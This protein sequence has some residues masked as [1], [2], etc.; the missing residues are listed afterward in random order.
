V[1]RHKAANPVAESNELMRDS[2]LILDE[3]MRFLDCSKGSKEPSKSL[4]DV[5]VQDALN[6]AGFD[7]QAFYKR[8]GK[9][10]WSKKGSDLDW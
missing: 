8:G 4:L 2:Y 1:S 10:K 3:Y 7:E 9:F 5:G 6:K